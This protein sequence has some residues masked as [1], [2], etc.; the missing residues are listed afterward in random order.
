MYSYLN[1]SFKNTDSSS[2]ETSNLES[3]NHFIH[4]FHEIL[5]SYIVIFFSS[6]L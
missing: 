3:L 5:F 1:H 2:N 4:K 6:E